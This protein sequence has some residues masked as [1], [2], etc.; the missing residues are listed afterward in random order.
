MAVGKYMGMIV[1]AAAPFASSSSLKESGCTVEGVEEGWM[2]DAMMYY[3]FLEEARAG[4]TTLLNPAG[5]LDRSIKGYQYRNGMAQ[6]YAGNH[7]RLS[8]DL[9]WLRSVSTQLINNSAWTAEQRAKGFRDNVTRGLLPQRFY[10]S[11]DI[12]IPACKSD[13]FSICCCSSC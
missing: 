3:G 10:D 1:S 8:G 4:I 5:N 2:V 13:T 9:A 12:Q 7:A 6:Y 11:S